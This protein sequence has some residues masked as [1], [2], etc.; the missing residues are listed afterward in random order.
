MGDNL[1]VFLCF[2]FQGH[3][4]I[5]LAHCLPDCHI[6]MVENNEESVKR[7]ETRV[8]GTRLT[9][10]SLFQCNLNY[11]TGVFNIGVSCCG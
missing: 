6:I 4:G 10:L 5:V 9:N 2:I 3:V 1:F 7:A 8:Q 11:Y